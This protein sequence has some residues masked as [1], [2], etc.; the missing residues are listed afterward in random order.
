M[1]NDF[2]EILNFEDADDFSKQNINNNN[3]N[4]NNSNKIIRNSS[5]L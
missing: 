1:N 2:N 3:N 5:K 4:N